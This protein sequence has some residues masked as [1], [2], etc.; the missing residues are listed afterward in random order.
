[1]RT[2]IA[3]TLTLALATS[4]WAQQQAPTTKKP[5]A[6]ANA[7]AAAAP[8]DPKVEK[9]RVD[10]E[11]A[12]NRAEMD[13]VLAEWEVRSKKVVSLDVLFDRIDISPGWGNQYYQGRAMLQ[14]PDLAC[15]Q[16]QKYKI[17]A[18]GKK[19]LAKKDG[20]VVPQLEPEPF[21]RIVC[22]GSK[23]LQYDWNEKKIFIFPLDKDSRQKALQQGPLPFLFNLK[24]AEAKRRYSMT[25]LKQD[26]KDYL[27]GIRPNEDID[28]E[29]FEQAFL[30]LN[31]KTFLPDKLML[32]TVGNKE[33][34]EFV[35]AGELNTIRAN[36]ALDTKYFLDNRYAGWK[37]IDNPNGNGAPVQGKVVAPPAQPPRRQAAQPAGRP[38]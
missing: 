5:N 19:I 25:L 22:T 30:W 21:E 8:V 11:N 9:A 3:W 36:T 15:L 38:Q 16:F 32:Y 28:K 26:E 13:R 33:R 6:P 12:A 27:I 37:V 4:A 2:L 29:S 20:K 18:A 31:K 1:L 24:A 7:K 10:A 34:Q 35:F 23:V 14:S 17:D